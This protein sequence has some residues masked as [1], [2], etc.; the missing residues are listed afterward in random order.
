MKRLLVLVSLLIITGSPVIA[1]VSRVIELDRPSGAA[2]DRP[3]LI[4]PVDAVLLD[5]D[6]VTTPNTGALW[7][8]LGQELL[9]EVAPEWRD[10]D[11]AQIKWRNLRDVHHWLQENRGARLDFDDYVQKREA[12]SAFIYGE[13]ARLEPTLLE[14]RARLTAA[15]IK[16]ALASANTRFSV[17]RMIR[18]FQL[19]PVFD[20]T[21]SSEEASSSN[22]FSVDKSQTHLLAC[23]RLGVEPSRAMAVEDTS[24][25]IAAARRAGLITVGLRNGYNDHED[26]SEA[27]FVIHRLA[28][29]LGLSIA[30]DPQ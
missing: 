18:R 3:G 17:D 14:T 4:T 27:D 24:A 2:I 9:R 23:R 30:T 1:A 25:G 5:M 19:E 10:G 22:G 13:L 7:A 29:L 20:A 12:L 6:G 15:N 16:L 28:N 26:F 8:E 11:L 21:A